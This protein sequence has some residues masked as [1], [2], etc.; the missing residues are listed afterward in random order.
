[1][2]LRVLVGCPTAEIKAY[3]LEEYVKGLKALTYANKDLLLVDNSATPD[4]AARIKALGI[5]VVT[6]PPL[7]DVKERIA[8]SRNVLREKA[9]KEG[10]DYLLSLE[11]DV[12]PPPDVIERLLQHNVKVITG[13]Y[14]T[15]YDI[16]G[17]AKMRP[18]VWKQD[19]TNA[20]NVIFM[21]EEVKAARGK[22]ADLHEIASSGVGCILIH[23]SVLEKI[24]FRVANGTY[25][26]MPFCKDAAA[27]GFKVYADLAIICKHITN[28]NEQ[29]LNLPP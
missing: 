8:H 5:P 17:E 11:Q 26:D 21:N 23:R 25:D 6:D 12:I 18:L 22:K 3:C 29:I 9:L 19:P 7:A 15:I 27:N 2:A 4:Y 1:M 28:I 24:K 14:F 20:D 16:D 13:V 10:Y